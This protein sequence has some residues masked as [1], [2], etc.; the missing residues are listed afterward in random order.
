M[1]AD[2]RLEHRGVSRWSVY[3]AVKRGELRC[4]RIGDRLLF[5][6]ENLRSFIDAHLGTY[7]RRR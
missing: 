1:E 5:R 3:K 6:I 2:A 7:V 4:V